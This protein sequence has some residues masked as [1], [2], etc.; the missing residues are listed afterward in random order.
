MSENSKSGESPVKSI[1]SDYRGE[2]RKIV[3]PSREETFKHTV[4][5]IVVSLLFG[6]YIAL[7]DFAFGSVY[8]WFMTLIQ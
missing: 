8:S 1:F 7:T 5:V 3:W 4:T 2:F 6:A